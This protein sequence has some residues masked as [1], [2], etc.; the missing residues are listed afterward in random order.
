[1]PKRRVTAESDVF[2][3]PQEVSRTKESFR[4]RATKHLGKL[5][6]A[7]AAVGMF[8]QLG[9]DDVS[10]KIE[11]SA[12]PVV[13][14]TVHDTVTTTVTGEQRKAHFEEVGPTVVLP[15]YFGSN[16]TAKP[17]DSIQRQN[18]IGI[19]NDAIDT[20][21]QDSSTK[22]TLTIGGEA[23][24]E[25]AAE[26]R[27][28]MS[29]GKASQY[30]LELAE[31]RRDLAYE[32]AVASIK[33]YE[34]RITVVKGEAKEVLLTPEDQ[35]WIDNVIGVRGMNRA[36]FMSLYDGNREAL[37]LSEDEARTLKGLIDD[38]RGSPIDRTTHK[39]GIELGECDV[40]LQETG[41]EYRQ[42]AKMTE[43]SSRK[44]AGLLPLV[45][46]P[47]IA[48]AA[49]YMRRKK[50]HANAIPQEERI[51]PSM[52]IVASTETY[53]IHE[54][55]QTVWTLQDKMAEIMDV[56][57]RTYEPLRRKGRH[58]KIGKVGLL[59]G[60]GVA[61]ATAIASAVGLASTFE[62]T[63]ELIPPPEIQTKAAEDCIVIESIPAHTKK[64]AWNSNFI[65]NTF[66]GVMDMGRG[67]FPSTKEVP[68]VE[69]KVPL[70]NTYIF[71]TNGDLIYPKI[72]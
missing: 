23:S 14:E 46:V 39:L 35:L 17:L 59:I 4:T 12:S 2:A 60:G 27:L 10:S 15:Q 66:K 25:S 24:D 72:G 26:S 18:V 13:M 44:E 7:A 36:T 70:G 3:R 71:N 48:A 67:L 68:A 65:H 38:H 49:L 63:T 6:M 22:I 56:S 29:F 30:N 57:K 9:G 28:D 33:G 52:S 50:K 20:V 1:M 58:R 55:Q 5:A 11:R 45:A 21:D 19:I 31:Q 53:Q 51:D 16:F 54:P 40:V 61:A 8:A 69:R 64:T 47:V 34:D 62:K 41:E 43:V 32:Q 37:H 42:V